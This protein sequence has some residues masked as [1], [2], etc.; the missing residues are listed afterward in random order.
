MKTDPEP[1]GELVPQP[2]D[3]PF[4]DVRL[5]AA[6]RA[7]FVLD[8]PHH[9]VAHIPGGHGR[10]M[11]GFDNLASRRVTT[12]RMPWAFS[13]VS[14]HGWDV[15]GV[16][17]R[18]PDWFQDAD[19]SAALIRLRSDGFF[20][21]YQDVAM[22]G[23]SMGGFGALAFAPLAPG[24]TVLAMAPQ[25][26]LD[27]ERAPFETRYRYARSI[28]TWDGPFADAATGVRSAGRAYVIWDPQEALDHAHVARLPK[29]EN[30]ELL[31]VSD[32]GHKIPPALLKMGIL[33]PIALSG[34]EGSLDPV[35]FRQLLRARRQSIPWIQSLLRRADAHGHRTLTMAA[36]QKA[37][38]DRPH[39]KLRREVKARRQRNTSKVIAAGTGMPPSQ[40]S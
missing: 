34:L 8:L 26:T 23:A 37:L 6:A 17:V 40:T 10:L 25:S 27:E 2:K 30:L 12:G 11:V 36:A 22:Y 31:P 33:K 5:L 24:C 38:N 19:L 13:L 39:W 18:R 16:M 9:V 20:A 3:D 4:A 15:L 29:S 28:T 35:R 21:R 7:G 1:T 32:V 14:S